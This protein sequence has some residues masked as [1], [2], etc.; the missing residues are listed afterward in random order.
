MFR[1][2][3]LAVQERVDVGVRLP[4]LAGR[5]HRVDPVP[6]TRCVGNRELICACVPAVALRPRQAFLVPTR[7]AEAADEARRH[8]APQLRD[9]DAFPWRRDLKQLRRQEPAHAE[10][11]LQEPVHG[12]GGPG[13]R[14][15]CQRQAVLPA[16]DHV[17]GVRLVAFDRSGIGVKARRHFATTNEY[18]RLARIALALRDQSQLRTTHALYDAHEVRRRVADRRQCRVCDH[19]LRP[20]LAVLDQNQVSRDARPPPQA[21]PTPSPMHTGLLSSMP[22]FVT[23]QVNIH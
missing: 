17:A 8:H 19:H 11:V 9:G 5:E 23:I 12:I 7:A 18:P 22:S 15:A 2:R 10:L 6:E 13:R 20:R 3:A 16:G 4:V 14:V 21:R 1:D